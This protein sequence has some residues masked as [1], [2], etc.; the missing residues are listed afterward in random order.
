M[1]WY[2]E[3]NGYFPKINKSAMDIARRNAT[4]FMEVFNTRLS[5]I[6]D[7]NLENVNEMLHG[8]VEEFPIMSPEN[9]LQT[10]EFYIRYNRYL[11]I[12]LKDPLKSIYR[13]L[14]LNQ[15]LNE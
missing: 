6:A 10:G 12:K 4:I 8:L 11:N 15:L 5:E 2:L 13:D 1:N 9:D 3:T 7:F 14:K